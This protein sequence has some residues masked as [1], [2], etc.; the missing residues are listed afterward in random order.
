MS[1]RNFH[2]RDRR[3]DRGISTL[4]SWAAAMVLLCSTAHAAVI[5]VGAS[6]CDYTDLQAAVDAAS[7]GDELRL[8][9]QTFP[10]AFVS[11]QKSLSIRGGYSACGDSSPG[12]GLNST[13]EGNGLDGV[14]AVSGGAG[15]IVELQRLSITGGGS[16]LFGGGVSVSSGSTLRLSTVTVEG[17]SAEFGGGIFIG[18]DSVLEHGGPLTVQNNTADFGGG[19]F[20]NDRAVLDFTTGGFNAIDIGSNN[21]VNDGGGVYVADDGQ[22][23]TDSGRP[24]SV[25]MNQAGFGG[26]IFAETSAVIDARGVTVTSNVADSDGGGLY[27]A[28]DRKA[29]VAT[30]ISFDGD[31]LIENNLATRGGGVALGAGPGYIVR[32]GGDIFSNLTT[33][34][35]GGIWHGGGGELSASAVFLRGNQAGGNGGC[36]FQQAGL[37]EFGFLSCVGNRADADGGGAF[38][39]DE[40]ELSVSVQAVFSG[41]RAGANGGGI[42]LLA[43]F[44]FMD[45]SGPDLLLAHSNVAETGNGGGLYSSGGAVALRYAV[46]GADGLG[47][48]APQGSG[49]GAYLSSGFFS[50]MWNT[51]VVDNSASGSGGGLYITG[52]GGFEFLGFPDEASV[53]ARGGITDC[54]ISLLDANRYCAEIRG[55]RSG[56]SGG[57]VHVSSSSTSTRIRNTAIVANRGG[58][59]AAGIYVDTPELEMSNVLVSRHAEYPAIFVLFQNGLVLDHASV[60]YNDFGVRGGGSET[61]AVSRSLFWGNGSDFLPGGDAVISGECNLSKDFRVPDRLSGHPRFI[62]TSRGEYRLSDQSPAVDG[63]ASSPLLV[64]LDGY[65]RPAGAANDI[66]AFEGAW[67]T[68]EVL[69]ADSFE[70]GPAAAPLP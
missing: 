1:T 68:S 54:D 66:G 36:H 24:F 12:L 62:A 27:V 37:T 46:L 34:D 48:A 61:M 41:N 3:P 25:D 16:T 42:A 11:I 53:P 4:V 32:V 17:N 45:G 13:L 70:T 29:A 22:L 40:G 38:V 15:V 7:A 60:L 31:S 2:R 43:G 47:N 69:L 28:G 56:G 33:G 63:C 19:I 35:G 57:G 30:T 67:G 8:R 49:G 50:S 20:A 44:L 59:P 55:N 9:A 5:T 51:R 52:S 14:V 21:A 64:D 10:V 39:A 65:R 18:P 23:L 26:G 58:N 6:D